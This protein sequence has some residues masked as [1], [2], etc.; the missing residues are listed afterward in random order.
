MS[1]QGPK[2]PAGK[3]GGPE[4]TRE[5]AK[6]FEAMFLYELLKEMR[7]ASGGGLFGKGLS[8]EVYQTLFDMEIARRLAERGTGISDVLEKALSRKEVSNPAPGP[9]VEEVHGKPSSGH[10]SL[11]VEGRITSSYGLRNDPFTGKSRFHKG[12]D[13]AAPRGTPIYPRGPGEVIFSGT[14]SGYGN[15]VIIRHPDGVVTRYAHNEK[16]LVEAG[17]EVDG[18]SPIGLVGSTGRATGPHLHYEVLVDGRPVDPLE[19]TGKEDV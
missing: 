12:L 8:G 1:L 9:P 4:R 19:V 3:E 14:L 2:A 11:P 17:E 5:A 13:I 18:T 15:I 10:R 16:N 7:A 6:E